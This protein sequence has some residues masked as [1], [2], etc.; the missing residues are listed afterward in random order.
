MFLFLIV[1]MHCFIPYCLLYVKYIGK[2]VG[3]AGLLTL[4]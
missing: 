1:L 4:E 3:A 2:Y